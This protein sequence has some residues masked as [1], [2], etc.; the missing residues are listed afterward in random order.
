[1][2]RFIKVMEDLLVMLFYQREGCFALDSDLVLFSRF[3]R[4]LTLLKKMC[5]HMAAGSSSMHA[6]VYFLVVDFVCGLQK[7]IVL[8]HLDHKG[9]SV[10]GFMITV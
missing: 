8:H 2:A 6:A 5:R 3:H 7:N 10:N 9:L 1:M 4:F